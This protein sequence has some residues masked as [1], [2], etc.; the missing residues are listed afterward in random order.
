MAS[1]KSLAN[2]NDYYT[3][4]VVF[5]VLKQALTSLPQF[6]RNAVFAV[7][8]IGVAFSGLM[9]TTFKRFCGKKYIGQGPSTSTIFRDYWASYWRTTAK[10]SIPWRVI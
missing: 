4:N 9:K 3:Q 5:C 2:V 7:Y 8:L 10:F 1:T 6:N